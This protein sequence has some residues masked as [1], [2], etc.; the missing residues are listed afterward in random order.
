MNAVSS[1][2]NQ[3]PLVV[4]RLV[5]LAGFEIRTLPN[6]QMAI[7]HPAST[8]ISKFPITLSTAGSTAKPP[9]ASH[10]T[11]PSLPPR[12]EPYLPDESAGSARNRESAKPTQRGPGFPPHFAA[13][14]GGRPAGG[15][16]RGP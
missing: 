2:R 3:R 7:T 5:N 8:A 9:R 13:L 16:P 4:P 14:P 10:R 11:H 6:A 1:I 15:P 12:A